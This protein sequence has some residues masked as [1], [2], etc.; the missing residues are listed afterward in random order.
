[1][2]YYLLLLLVPLCACCS[3]AAQKQYTLRKSS[4]VI[5]F[6]AFTSLIALLFFIVTSGFDLAFDWRLTPYALAFA[7][8]YSAAW[9]GTVLALRYGLMAITTLIISCSLVFPI[10]YGVMRGEALT[11]TNIVGMALLLAALV[12][13]NLKLDKKD[14]FSLK[15]LGCV[16]VAL[17]GNGVCTLSQNMQKFALGDGYTHEF[18]IIA[19]S[20]SF[21][22]LMAY[23]FITSRDIRGELR[24]CLPYA[25]CNGVA[26]AA[27]NFLMLT[28]IGNIPNTVLYPTNAALGMIATFLLGY[29]AYKERF[30]KT[31]YI[32]YALGVAS[33]VI[34]NL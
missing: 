3:S 15:W 13:V 22:L 20:A 11:T 32:G 23:A 1:M 19:L 12:L 34:L 33:I 29:I 25:A 30:S 31:Q 21:V 7:V 4:N 18:M 10:I 8:S 26:N 24:G 6:S 2:I 9:V 5:L 14:R 28:I 16:L 27:Q 17:V